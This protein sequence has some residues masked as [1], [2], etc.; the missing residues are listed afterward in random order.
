MLFTL[1]FVALAASVFYASASFVA[2]QTFPGMSP[3]AF[4]IITYTQIVLVA[5]AV[6][7]LENADLGSCSAQ[8]NVCLCSNRAFVNSTTICI[9]GACTGADLTNAELLARDICQ[10]VARFCPILLCFVIDEQVTGRADWRM[11]MTLYNVST[12]RLSVNKVNRRLNNSLSA[13]CFCGRFGGL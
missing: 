11:S 1:T 2:R 8:Y 13:F 6:P 10:S 9:E 7:C 3:N 12:V 4:F 5:C